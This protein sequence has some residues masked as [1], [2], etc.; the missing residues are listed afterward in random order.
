MIP[1]LI[2]WGKQKDKYYLIFHLFHI[3]FPSVS[4]KSCPCSYIILTPPLNPIT[5]HL[6]STSFYLS[7]TLSVCSLSLY[8]P[9]AITP[10]CFS[11]FQT[12]FKKK[13]KS[14]FWKTFSSKSIFLKKKEK[15]FFWKTFSSKSI[16]LKK[17]FFGKHFL[18]NPFFWKKRRFFWKH[19]LVN[20]FFWKKE[21]RFFWKTF[22]SKST[23]LKNVWNKEK[24]VAVIAEGEYKLREHTDNAE[25]R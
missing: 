1:I 14:L 10:K 3:I 13:E 9:S 22:S 18:V 17:A 6:L 8:S 16:F 11:L 21:K 4:Y 20:P 2:H 12:F 24:H 5:S 25:E 7:L 15:R 23:F 19:F